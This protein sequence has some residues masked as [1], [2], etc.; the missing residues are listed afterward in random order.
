MDFDEDLK[1]VG[2]A[3]TEESEEQGI[4]LRF[5]CHSLTKSGRLGFYVEAARI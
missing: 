4:T 3:G 1:I 5:G 2:N